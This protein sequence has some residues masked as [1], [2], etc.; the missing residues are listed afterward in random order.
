LEFIAW[1]ATAN[2]ADT[3]TVRVYFGATL[4]VQAIL[5]ASSPGTWVI[6]GTIVRTS[7]TTQLAVATTTHTLTAPVAQNGSASPGE[8]LS[9]AVNMRIT[10]ESSTATNNNITIA[11][12]IVK[13]VG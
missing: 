10:G 2:N 9:G 4:F 3:K 6:R 1:G 11:A 8:T 13:R 5:T 12:L 7:A